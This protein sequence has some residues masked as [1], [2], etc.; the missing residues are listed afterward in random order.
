ML[1]FASSKKVLLHPERRG[2]VLGCRFPHVFLSA[3][4]CVP[5]LFLVNLRM[6][7]SS[8]TLSSPMAHRSMD[9]AAHLS[10]HVPREPGVLAE[11][12]VATGVPQLAPVLSHLVALVEAK[13]QCTATAATPQG[14][15]QRAARMRSCK[16]SRI[17]GAPG[18][19]SR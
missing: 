4:T 8:E 16:L 13:G 9:N 19:L 5:T 18:W 17:L 1:F 10:H 12:P 6:H 15:P 2:S 14:L 11:A 3:Q 7:L